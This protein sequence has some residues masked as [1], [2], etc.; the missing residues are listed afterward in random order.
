MMLSR[1]NGEKESSPIMAAA[2]VR[3]VDP[4]PPL[5]TPCL[6]IPSEE[7]TAIPTGIVAVDTFNTCSPTTLEEESAPRPRPILD[8]TV[9]F[10]KTNT[11]TCTTTAPPP[12]RAPLPVVP[13]LLPV[14]ALLP[15]LGRILVPAL[16]PAL[17]RILVPLILQYPHRLRHPDQHPD[18]TPPTTTTILLLLPER[19]ERA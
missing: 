2:G 3:T 10:P 9:R 19:V 12:L 6:P 5:P 13:V 15:A 7:G 1:D 8:D 11:R 4:P 14:P 18:R 16:L 17:G